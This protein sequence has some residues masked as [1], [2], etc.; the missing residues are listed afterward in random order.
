MLSQII[1]QIISQLPDLPGDDLQEIIAEC[2]RLLDERRAGEPATAAPAAAAGQT[3]DLQTA[4][5]H[6]WVETKMV[7][8]CGPYAYLRWWSGRSK[9]SKYLGK[10][11]QS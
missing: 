1:S 10:V 11:K 8:G 9:K 4:I 7:N 6:G 2:M 3:N 5:A